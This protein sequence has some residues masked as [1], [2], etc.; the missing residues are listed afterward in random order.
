MAI[1][2]LCSALTALGPDR[3]SK[4]VFFLPI[5]ALSQSNG[6]RSWKRSSV[7]RAFGGCLGTKRR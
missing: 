4:L 7:L 5:V 2:I 6:H 1:P 3:T